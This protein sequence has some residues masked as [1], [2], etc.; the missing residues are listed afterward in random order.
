MGLKKDRPP[1]LQANVVC[2]EPMPGEKELLHE[3]LK[4]LRDDHL[5]ALIGK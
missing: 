4:T 3:F 5:E 2:A 1:I